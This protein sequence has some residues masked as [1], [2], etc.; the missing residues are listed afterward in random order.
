MTYVEFLAQQRRELEEP[1]DGIWLDSSLLVWTNQAANDFARRTKCLRDEQ[2]ATSVVN[3]Y[4][5]AMPDDTLEPIAV[6][7]ND[8]K[9]RREDYDVWSDL[10]LFDAGS[11]VPTTFAV[12]GNTLVLWPTPAAAESIRYFRYHYPDT[13]EDD[14]DMPFSGQYDEALGYFVRAKAHEQ[15]NDWESANHLMMRYFETCENV[16][17]QKSM[18]RQTLRVSTAPREVY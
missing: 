9:L 4:A 3:Q 12:N 16:L 7:F 17:S 14:S 11:G 13:I 18:E 6:Y 2:Y 15:V 5:Y 10:S 1:S 8:A